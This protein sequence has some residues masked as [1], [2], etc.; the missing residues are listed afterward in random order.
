MAETDGLLTAI[1]ALAV[2]ICLALGGLVTYRE[3]GSP[4]SAPRMVTVDLVRILNAERKALPKLSSDG[5]PSLKLLQIGRQIRPTI[6]QLAGKDTVVLVKQSVVGGDLPD[7]TDAVLDSLGLPKNAPTVSLTSALS[8]APTTSS[9][10][11]GNIWKNHL[12]QMRKQLAED[13][14]TAKSNA[15]SQKLP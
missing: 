5:D 15:L 14:A 11:V 6:R 2:V 1:I 13:R 7:I 10:S 9:L 12:T 4:Q 8:D 3:F